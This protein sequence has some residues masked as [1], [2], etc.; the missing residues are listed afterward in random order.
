MD[1]EPI[2]F[3]SFKVLLHAWLIDNGII[4]KLNTS[5]FN[6]FDFKKPLIR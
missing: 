6:D 1:T 4:I 3:S 5:N 2:P